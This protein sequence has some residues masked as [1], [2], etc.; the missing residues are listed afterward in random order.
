MGVQDLQLFLEKK[1]FHFSFRREDG[2]KDKLDIPQ[3]IFS[4][5]RF[6]QSAKLPSDLK[7]AQEEIGQKEL[8]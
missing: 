6:S 1:D 2:T 7:L 8:I 5:C 4:S 3:H